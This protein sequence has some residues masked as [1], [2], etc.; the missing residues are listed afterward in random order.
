MPNSYKFTSHEIVLNEGGSYRQESFEGRS[1]Y[2]CPVTM[3]TP[4]VYKANLGAVLYSEEELSKPVPA[5][6]GR[7]ITAYHPRDENG[8]LTPANVAETLEVY[9][10]GTVFNA[11]YEDKLKAEAW[12][13]VERTRQVDD[14]I[15]VAIEANQP[16]NVSIG[17]HVEEEMISGTYNEREYEKVARDMQP[18]HLAILF[19]KRGACSLADGAGLLVAESFEEKLSEEL[20]VATIGLV[21]NQLSHDDIRAQ[22]R[23]HFDAIAD[24][25][26]ADGYIWMEDVSSDAVVV[27]M[28]DTFYRFGH[29]TT[30]DVVSVDGSSMKVVRRKTDYVVNDESC[31][32]EEELVMDKQEMVAAIVASSAVFN[33]EDSERLLALEEASLTD[34]HTKLVGNNEE[35]KSVE[36]PAPVEEL[37]EPKVSTVPTFNEFVSNAPSEVRMVINEGIDAMN[38][39]RADL[40]QKILVKGG[41]AYTADDL[42]SESLA[43]LRKLAKFVGNVASTQKDA[44]TDDVVQPI[45]FGAVGFTPAFNEEEDGLPNDVLNILSTVG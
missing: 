19:D 21:N 23:A 25:D 16:V 28:N 40:T 5:W 36:T 6:N 24:T 31:P 43:S 22:I 11:K 1:H 15:I 20:R 4:G 17:V 2:I 18:D 3:M 14:R 30:D 44:L 42:V 34:L 35:P 38:R 39:E 32:L 33:E 9:K 8:D 10:I 37:E 13:D 12:I 29:T 45:Y 27:S 41:D 26:L 7:P